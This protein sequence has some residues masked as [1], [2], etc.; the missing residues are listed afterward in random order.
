MKRREVNIAAGAGYTDILA[1]CVSR[2]VVITEIGIAGVFVG[3]DYKTN[4][5]ADAFATVQ[6]CAAADSFELGDKVAIQGGY[7]NPVGWPAQTIRGEAVAATTLAKV[8]TAAGGGVATV[9]QVLE[10]D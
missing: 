2:Y 10:W 8:R 1:T 7:G 3:L 9:V 5:G 6:H 4:D